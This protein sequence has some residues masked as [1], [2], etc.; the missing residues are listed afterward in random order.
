MCLLL[1]KNVSTNVL[2]VDTKLL[3]KGFLSPGGPA[4]VT[5]CP[6]NG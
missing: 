5:A 1:M 3:L 6:V 4:S 2:A